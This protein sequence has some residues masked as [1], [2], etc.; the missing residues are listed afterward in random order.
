[1]ALF[2]DDLIRKYPAMQKFI[3]QIFLG[4]WFFSVYI[5]FFERSASLK[6]NMK[7]CEAIPGTLYVVSEENAAMNE[8]TE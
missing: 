6:L 7:L 2:G 5:P 3:Q 4:F 1:M 8:N